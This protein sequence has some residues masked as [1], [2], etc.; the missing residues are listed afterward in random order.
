MN[1]EIKKQSRGQFIRTTGL[2]AIGTLLSPKELFSQTSPVITFRNEAAKA[3]IT[4]QAI[5]GN[6]HLL[7]GSGGNIGVFSGRDGMLIVDSGIGVSEQ[8]IHS[9]LA[10]IGD[11]QLKYVVNTHWHFDHAEGN[12]WMHKKGAT[13]IAHENTR[14]NL[15]ST[16]RVKDWNYTFDPAPGAALPTIVFK[17]EHKLSFNGSE[18]RMKYYNPCHTNS[19]ISVYFSEADILQVGDTWWNAHYPFIDHDTGGS[20]DGMIEASNQNLSLATNKT[21]IIPGHGAVGDRNQLLQFRDMLVSVRDKVS[22]LKKEGRSMQEVV[23]AKPTSA[24]DA[25]YG[26][27]AVDGS[28]FTRLVYHDV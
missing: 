9:A 5:R 2:I 18:I 27:F 4:K 15:A 7:E 3:K 13:I 14:N 1:N 8:K 6:I 10:S 21:K 12:E 17:D 20:I 23:D 16:I 26:T 24:F 19:D 25:T 22:R 11:K 28:F